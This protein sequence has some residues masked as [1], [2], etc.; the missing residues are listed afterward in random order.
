MMAMHDGDRR[1]VTFARGCD[2]A[3]RWSGDVLDPPGRRPADVANPLT[4]YLANYDVGNGIWKWDHYHEIYHRHLNKFVGVAVDVLEIGIYSGGSLHMWRSYF[5]PGSRMYGVDIESACK[6]CEQDGVRVFIGDQG[7]P[8]FWSEF[9]E[10]VAGVDIVIDDG[11]H[12]AEQQMVTLEEMLPRLRPGGVYICEDIHGEGNAFAGFVAGL[13]S[14]LGVTNRTSPPYDEIGPGEAL[15]AAPTPFQRSVHSVHC[16]PFLVVIE[17]H[18]L[19]P[20]R[21]SA[22]K[23]GTLW[24]PFL[25][26][27]ERDAEPGQGAPS[28][29]QHRGGNPV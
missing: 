11:G 5:G 3:D 27:D 18:E 13:I 14:R 15:T 8:L 17:K 4:A 26:K 22:P 28:S 19:P 9:N 7:D 10:Q 21:F 24:Q 2:Y 25:S 23:R 20:K 6:L 16:Y 29:M 1:A 12:T